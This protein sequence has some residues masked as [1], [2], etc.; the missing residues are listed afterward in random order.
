MVVLAKNM[1]S[2]DVLSQKTPLVIKILAGGPFTALA[3]PPLILQENFIFRWQGKASGDDIGKHLE[4]RHYFGPNL[5]KSVFRDHPAWIFFWRIVFSNRVFAREQNLDFA[6]AIIRCVFIGCFLLV[7]GIFSPTT[8]A[9]ET[10]T[11]D[12]RYEIHQGYFRL[13]EQI[14]QR[15]ERQAFRMEGIGDFLILP[16]QKNR[17]F[18]FRPRNRIFSTFTHGKKEKKRRFVALSM[19]AKLRRIFVTSPLE[20]KEARRGSYSCRHRHSEILLLL[21]RFHCRL[22]PVSGQA[23]KKEALF[24]GVRTVTLSRSHNR[25]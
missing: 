11:E 21:F 17:Q 14:Q 9:A 2:N 1:S 12:T 20:G 24:R 13:K 16:R 18:F 25:T 19:N 4:N 15:I 3:L 6:S 23:L 8:T 10:D 7:V 5:L 22:F